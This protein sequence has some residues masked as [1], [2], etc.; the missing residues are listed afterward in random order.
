[1][2]STNLTGDTAFCIGKKELLLTNLFYGY[3]PNKLSGV[4][5]RFI[6][7]HYPLLYNL[8]YANVK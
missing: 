7:K 2:S 5:S 8:K 4:S 1:M 6:K 3:N